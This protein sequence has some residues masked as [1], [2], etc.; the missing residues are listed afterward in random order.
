LPERVTLPS[1][2]T[3]RRY[4]FVR[5]LALLVA[6]VSAAC[7]SFD[8]ALVFAGSKAG[9]TPAISIATLDGAPYTGQTP[10]YQQTVTFNT[11]IPTLPGRATAEVVLSCYQDVDGDGTIDPTLGGPDTVYSWIDAPTATFSFSGQG[12][13]STWSLLGG[14]PA[15]CRADLDAYDKAQATVLATTGD[16]AVSR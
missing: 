1:S 5:R 11:T 13:T 3:G 7:L 16:F 15:V 10:V 8:S 14:G 6:L 4:L 12:Q 9:I 2:A